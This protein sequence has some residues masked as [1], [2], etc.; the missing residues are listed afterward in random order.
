M[1]GS[2]AQKARVPEAGIAAHDERRILKD[3]GDER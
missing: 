3:K 1:I 2:V